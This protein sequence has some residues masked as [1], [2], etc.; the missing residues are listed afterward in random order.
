MPLEV[1]PVRQCFQQY[2]VDPTLDILHG[3]Y[4]TKAYPQ[5]YISRSMVMYRQFFTGSANAASALWGTGQSSPAALSIIL[6]QFMEAA[7]LKFGARGLG[8]SDGAC[9]SPNQRIV[10]VN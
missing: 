8:P 9:F 6:V 2:P 7:R 5:G 1:V 4:F 10:F 3:F